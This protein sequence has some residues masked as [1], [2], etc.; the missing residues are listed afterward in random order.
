[1]NT[2]CQ[3]KGYEENAA[4]IGDWTETNIFLA[5]F[6]LIWTV[7]FLISFF[8]TSRWWPPGGFYHTTREQHQPLG[9]ETKSLPVSFNRPVDVSIKWDSGSHLAFKHKL[10]KSRPAPSA[11]VAS[12]VTLPAIGAKSIK[13]CLMLIVELVSKRYHSECSVQ[14]LTATASFIILLS[15]MPAVTNHV[16]YCHTIES[17]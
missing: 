12:D 8:C 15:L 7:I 9:Q 4:A 14:Y 13:R 11:V 17:S 5:V 1:M 2:L 16:A 6:C 10:A 3:R